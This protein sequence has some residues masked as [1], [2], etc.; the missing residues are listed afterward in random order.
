MP[1]DWR[2]G[3]WRREWGPLLI[4]LLSVLM[5]GAVLLTSVLRRGSEGA[6]AQAA[7]EAAKAAQEAAAAA[8]A[9]AELARQTGSAGTTLPTEAETQAALARSLQGILERKAANLTPGLA[10]EEAQA[11][12]SKAAELLIDKMKRDASGD[13]AR[14]IGRTLKPLDAGEQQA[15]QDDALPIFREALQQAAS[16]AG[17]SGVIDAILRDLKPVDI[18]AIREG[19]WSGLGSLPWDLITAIVSNIDFGDDCNECCGCKQDDKKRKGGN[20]EGELPAGGT[21][22]TT[23][24][25][26]CPKCPKPVTC[27]PV[28]ECR[29]GTPGD[30]SVTTEPVLVTF[31]RSGQPEVA[32]DA[33][34]IRK[35]AAALAAD[36]TLSVV[37]WAFTDG[38][39]SE[40]DNVEL[41]R[42]RAVSVTKGLEANGVARA[43]IRVAPLGE[44][45]APYDTAT[46]RDDV[47]NRIVRIEF[48]RS[49]SGA[50]SLL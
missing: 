15:A 9:A 27:P 46:G 42:A 36:R 43:R 47:R 28:A 18:G 2:R 26:S 30:C 32:R 1:D 35:A 33:P 34:A 38:K 11:V 20:G 3:Q 12:A 31:A 45:L 7:V 5:L 13:M 6:A 10:P 41:A 14:K 29:N 49:R 17:S 23:P 48:V 44:Y 39:G 8:K 40:L 22:P 37:L 16:A 21:C 24:K 4:G 50:A 19:F 25:E